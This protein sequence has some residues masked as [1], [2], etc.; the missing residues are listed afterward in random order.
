MDSLNGVGAT[1]TALS[2][3]SMWFWHGDIADGP[4]LVLRVFGFFVEHGQYGVVLTTWATLSGSLLR[5][6]RDRLSSVQAARRSRS[7]ARR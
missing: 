7:F 5:F 4:M 3:F 2:V 1:L 6:I